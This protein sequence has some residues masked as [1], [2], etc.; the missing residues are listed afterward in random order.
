MKKHLCKYG[1]GNE[2]IKQFKDGSWCCSE[3][4]IQ[5]PVKRKQS[6]ESHMGQKAW[7]KDL[8][9]GP[10]SKKTKEILSNIRKGKPKSESHKRNIGIG[11]GKGPN[12]Y[13]WKGYGYISS[14]EKFCECG[15][16]G[17]IEIKPHHKYTGIPRFISGH[18]S[19]TRNLSKDHK[20][21][22]GNG[23]RNKIRS[24]EMKVTT[25]I[26]MKKLWE[27]PDSI[28]NDE[29]WRKKK[30]ESNKGEGNFL[31]GKFGKDAPGWVG[32]CF[33]YW[34]GK[35]WE[36]FGSG[37]CENCYMSNEEHKQRWGQRLHMHNT[38][39][40]K[41]YTIMEPEAWMTLCKTCHSGLEATLKNNKILDRKWGII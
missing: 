26:I 2:G 10:L 29:E 39:D 40:P 38:L 15:C 28:F 6:S 22:I 37:C 9:T 20:R 4:Y 31:Y 11:V 7:N 23:N 34:H 25:S 3:Y 8:K 14:Y 13:H 5:C 35:A 27:D 1:C 18:N 30:G 41:D 16:G 24:E 19:R 12:N 33:E 21:R 17:R 32:G 36:L